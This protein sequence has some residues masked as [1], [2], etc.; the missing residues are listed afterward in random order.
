MPTSSSSPS[1]KTANQPFR[2]GLKELLFVM[3]A[4][5]ISCGIIAQ[6][7]TA[8][9]VVGIVVGWLFLAIGLKS[10]KVTNGLVVFCIVCVLV[11]GYELLPRPGSYPPSR[12]MQCSNNLKQIALAMHNYHDEHGSFPPAY[13]A[14]ASG[15]PMHSWRVLLLPYLERQDIYGAYDFNEPWDGPNNSKLAAVWP[16]VYRCPSEDQTSSQIT[17]YVAVIGANT[18]WPGSD[19]ASLREIKDGAATTLLVVECANSGIHWMEPRDLHLSQMSPTINA[20]AGQ[21]MCSEHPGGFQAAMCDGSV[22]FIPESLSADDV[23]AL[24]TVDG[25]EPAPQW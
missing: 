21:G 20:T 8:G 7:G 16:E 5:G 19:A 14:D 23:R 25:G 12:R 17:S 9:A 2:C 4:I 3:L 1:D 22:R 11:I 10:L 13:I 15:K 24:L 18:A 6:I